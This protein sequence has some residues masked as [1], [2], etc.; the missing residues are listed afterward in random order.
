MKKFAALL[1]MTFLLPAVTVRA[2]RDL[3]FVDDTGTISQDALIQAAEPLLAR[4]ARIGVYVVVGGGEG[5]LLDNLRTDDMLNESGNLKDD[6][7]IVYISIDPDRH[8]IRYGDRWRSA[9]DEYLPDQQIDSFMTI[10][11][12][13]RD[14]EQAVTSAL[15]NVDTAL[16]L[17]NNQ[18]QEWQFYLLGLVIVLGFF[19]GLARTIFIVVRGVFKVGRKLSS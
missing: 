2:Q 10:Y 7:I 4:D 18:N 5:D 13:Q 3:F 15:R 9:L 8:E 1:V 14:Y 16:I 12:D 6:A 19:I 17:H 11:L